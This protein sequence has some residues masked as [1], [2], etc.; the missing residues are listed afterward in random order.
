MH[1]LQNNFTGSVLVALNGTSIKSSELQEIK[2]QLEGE[3]TGTE[4]AGKVL[5]VNNANSDGKIEINRL[6]ADNAGDLYSQLSESSIDDIFV[7]FRMNPILVG[8]NVSTGFSKQE[9]QQAYSLFDSTVI[10]PIKKMFISEMKKLGV[11]ISFNNFKINWI[12]NG[13]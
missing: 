3:Y 4:N 5:L 10:L 8:K 6:S 1:N 9:F 12:S 13:E 11:T 2:A 7:A